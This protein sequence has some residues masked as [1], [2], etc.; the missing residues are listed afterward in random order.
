M[1]FGA[2]VWSVEVPACQMDT[3]AGA[4]PV[5]LNDAY[6]RKEAT[7]QMQEPHGDVEGT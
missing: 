4:W 5:E 1:F 2:E 6:L 7:T 3:A